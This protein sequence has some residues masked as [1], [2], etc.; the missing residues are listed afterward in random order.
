[1]NFKWLQTKYST[2]DNLTIMK[3]GQLFESSI[4][5]Y[6][7]PNIKQLTYA[8]L[9][10]QPSIKWASQ[11]L[12]E[13]IDKLQDIK[14]TGKC[15]DLFNLNTIQ[16]SQL[17]FLKELNIDFDGNWPYENEAAS[18]IDCISRH[19]TLESLGLFQLKWL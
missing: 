1:M 10:N 12:L 11:I 19:H 16:L 17:G 18:F 6:K 7:N 2:I 14:L 5:S 3:T 9:D 13:N 15:D 4:E 8:S